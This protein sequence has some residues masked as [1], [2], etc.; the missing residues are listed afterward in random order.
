MYLYSFM[1]FVGIGQ[2]K[3][4]KAYTEEL[5]ILF[6]YDEDAVWSVRK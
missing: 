1:G 6:L 3:W 4:P 5:M 2:C